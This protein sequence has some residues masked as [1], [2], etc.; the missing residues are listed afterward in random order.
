MKSKATLT[1][2]I[3]WVFPHTSKLKISSYG[4]LH[5]SESNKNFAVNYCLEVKKQQRNTSDVSSK[6]CFPVEKKM[7]CKRKVNPILESCRVKS[8]TLCLSFQGKHQSVLYFHWGFQHRSHRKEENP[9]HETVPP[10]SSSCTGLL[11]P[12]SPAPVCGQRLSFSKPTLLSALL[13]PVPPGFCILAVTDMVSSSPGLWQGGKLAGTCLTGA[14]RD[15]WVER[16]RLHAL[17]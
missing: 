15:Q 6:V 1:P 9:C 11:T 7:I 12:G 4:C 2:C 14:L 10:L 16:W 5:A 3:N 13:C 17:L 8:V